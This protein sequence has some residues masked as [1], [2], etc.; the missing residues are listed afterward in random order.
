MSEVLVIKLTPKRKDAV[1]HVARANEVVELRHDMFWRWYQR[2][3]A[4]LPFLAELRRNVMLAHYLWSSED[5][6]LQHK[7][8][9]SPPYIHRW[10]WTWDPTRRPNC[11]RHPVVS[12]LQQ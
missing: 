6:R 1:W 8:S 4:Q 11:F 7:R 2:S 10:M 9:S 5:F 3:C 12:S